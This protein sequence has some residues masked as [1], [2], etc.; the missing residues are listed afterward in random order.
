MTHASICSG[1]DGPALAA[2]WLGW[3]NLF[4]ADINEFTNIV[5]KY[6]YP[7]AESYTD[8]RTTDFKKW[9]GKVG[10]L[11]AGFP[12]QPFSVAGQ[13][14]GKDHDSYLWDETLRVVSE[15][16]P[17]W[18][19]GENVDGI[20]SMVLPGEETPLAGQTDLF[21]EEGNLYERTDSYIIER[22]CSDL[23]Q[24][25]YETYPVAFPACAVGA[26]HNR[27]RCFFIGFDTHAENADDIRR[28]CDQ[29]QEEPKAGRQREFS[30]GDIQRLPSDDGEIGTIADTTNTGF[31]DVC[32]S[33]DSVLSPLS[34]ADT[35]GSGSQT[36][37]SKQ[38]TTR[39]SRTCKERV[40]ANSDG[41]RLRGKTNGIRES[42][43]IDQNGSSNYWRNFPTQSP[44]CH[45]NDGFSDRLSATAFPKW[46][47]ASLTAL[48]N[49]IVP[50]QVYEILR[51]ID[52]I[53]NNA[54]NG[55]TDK[56]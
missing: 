48:G 32:E 3:Q 20:T 44:V 27:M 7:D 34:A 40:I 33:E 35:L 21:G 29:W 46:V 23:E 47:R 39:P 22:I 41:F 49:A 42:G 53:E 5:L 36:K 52:K 37:G 2:T 51:L 38:Q 1:I 50:Q 28:F 12:C 4:H 18:F 13:R 45:G 15:V 31:E 8:I 19:I 6:Y 54:Y 26:P 30:S 56:E 10:V 17:R 43:F 55:Q 16:R 25:G 14:T 11:T 9:R 24:L